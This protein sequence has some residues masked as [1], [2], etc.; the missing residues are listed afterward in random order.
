MLT[1][2]LAALLQPSMAAADDRQGQP[3]Q[4][5]QSVLP[6]LKRVQRHLLAGDLDRAE[7]ALVQVRKHP[8]ATKASVLSLEGLIDLQRGRYRAAASR[9]RKVLKLQATKVAVWLYLGQALYSLKDYDGALRAL[10]RGRKVGAKMPGYWVLKERCLLSLKRPHRAYVV[11]QQA[12]QRFPDDPQLLREQALILVELKLF[13]AALRQ[14][15]RYLRK[16][17]DDPY[18]YLILGEALRKAGGRDGAIQVLEQ[19]RIRFP[20][21]LEILARLAFTYAE[22]R[23]PVTAGRLFE[24]ASA[25]DPAL[26]Y[27]AAEQYR[28]GSKLRDAL[29]LNGMIVDQRR[30]LRQRL[31][32]LVAAE[33]W[34]LTAALEEPMRG[35]GLLRDADR[36]LIAYARL[37][38]GDLVGAE[39][40][41]SV[42]KER[43][44]LGSVRRLKAAIAR[45]RKAPWSCR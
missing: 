8:A 10:G 16:V 11:V 41:A 37:R 2:T 15:R 40:L 26:A 7:A 39:Q 33:R 36:Y 6:L 35:A 3:G 19:G 21:S 29:R 42:I 28:I 31:A 5:Q 13:S 32:I 43:S 14:G 22:K 18:S 27:E 12:L 38:A 17:P 25:L 4:Q 1:L 30:K 24:R 9:F 44:Y 20:G 23:M 34:H 45:C